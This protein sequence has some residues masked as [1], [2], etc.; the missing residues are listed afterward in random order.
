MVGESPATGFVVRV[1]QKREAGWQIV[2][3][4]LI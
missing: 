4:E 3:D 2:F 1:W